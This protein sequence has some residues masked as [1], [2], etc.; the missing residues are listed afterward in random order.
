MKYIVNLLH[1]ILT[2][3]H[4]IGHTR[5][6]HNAWAFQSTDEWRVTLIQEGLA[7][8]VLGEIQILFKNSKHKNNK[9]KEDFEKVLHE[10]FF[11]FGLFLILFFFGQRNPGK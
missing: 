7:I 10:D 3:D 5:S 4:C 6:V 8:N 1:N 2:V 11:C 9:K